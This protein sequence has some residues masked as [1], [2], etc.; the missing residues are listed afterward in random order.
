MAGKLPFLVLPKHFRGKPALTDFYWPDSNDF[1]RAD[2]LFPE[3]KY[4]RFY[5]I[6]WGKAVASLRTASY[7]I[8]GRQHAVYAACKARVPFA[9]S[10]GNTHKIKGL[11]ESAG[12]NIP[13]CD[14]PEKIREIIPMIPDLAGEYE[15]LFDWLDRQDYTSVIPALPRPII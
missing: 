11:I 9:A 8:T 4:L 3:A 5:K 1:R 15:K 6:S 10:E 12:V 7:L 13:I 2:A 14:T